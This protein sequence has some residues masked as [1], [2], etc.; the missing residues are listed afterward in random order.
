[1]TEL[2]KFLFDFD[3]DDVQLMEEIDRT[4]NDTEMPID[5]DIP[6]ES[7]PVTPTF[8]E[9]DLERLPLEKA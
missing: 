5:N 4:V 1:M 8:S 7:K 3:F 2:K 9:E 6:V